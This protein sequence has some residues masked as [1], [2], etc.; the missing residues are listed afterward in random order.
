VVSLLLRLLP[1]QQPTVSVSPAAADAASIVA[2]VVMV[3]GRQEIQR[4]RRL[5]GFFFN[6]GTRT[7][8]RAAVDRVPVPVTLPWVWYHVLLTTPLLDPK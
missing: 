2:A 4:G 5:G 6:K 3:Q 8:I 1:L 7:E